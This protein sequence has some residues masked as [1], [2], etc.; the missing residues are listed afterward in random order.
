M[1]ELELQ[2]Q[3]NYD[4]VPSSPEQ[5]HEPD[6]VFPADISDLNLGAVTPSLTP[7]SSSGNLQQYVVNPVGPS[8]PVTGTV[9]LPTQG[10]PQIPPKSPM[11]NCIKAYLPNNQKT[12][13]QYILR[14]EVTMVMVTVP[15]CIYDSVYYYPL[16]CQKKKIIT[17]T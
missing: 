11:R 2:E 3:Q 10:S 6:P 13:V 17:C 8:V 15:L 16:S 14:H 12:T 7:N 5:D 4:L 1:R 9:P